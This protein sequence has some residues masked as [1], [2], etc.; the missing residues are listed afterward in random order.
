MSYLAFLIYLSFV[1][2]SFIHAQVGYGPELGIGMSTT[3]FAPPTYPI[4]YTSASVSPVLSGRVGGLIDIPLNKHTY[5][6]A[7]LY[8]SR[9]GAVRSF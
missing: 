8:L 2:T 6:Q 5:F 1:F 9:K 4:P 7:G 3:R